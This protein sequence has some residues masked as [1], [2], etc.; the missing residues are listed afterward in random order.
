MG[1]FNKTWKYQVENGPLIEVQNYNDFFKTAENI[2]VDGQ[3]IYNSQRSQ[4][5]TFLNGLT[6]KT[7]NIKNFTAKIKTDDGLERS[8]KINMG[9]HLVSVIPRCHIYLDNILVGG[10]IEK[11]LFFLHGYVIF[12]FSF[13]MT[14]CV[15]LMVDLTQMYFRYKKSNTIMKNRIDQNDSSL[16]EWQVKK[17]M[18]INDQ[19]LMFVKG[20]EGQWRK[21]CEERRDYHCRLFSYATENHQDILKY[22]HLACMQGDLPSCYSGLIDSTLTLKNPLFQDFNR[23]LSEGCI[24][25]LKERTLRERQVCSYY[26]PRIFRID[27]DKEKLKTILGPLCK[28]SVDDACQNLRI[29]TGQ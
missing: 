5:K 17:F 26:A 3:E 24:A 19:Y 20:K 12:S 2:R 22:T 8:L 9:F 18:N 13:S 15:L 1:I 11:E 14:I 25:N 4:I 21:L 16:W 29:L 10:D 28:D 6:L 7:S 23:V 27:G